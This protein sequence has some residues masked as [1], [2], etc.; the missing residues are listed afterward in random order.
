MDRASSWSWVTKSAVVP[1]SR[2]TLWTS[3]RT[4]GPQS[5]VERRERLVE[6]DDLGLDGQGPRQ[7]HPLLLSS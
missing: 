3:A 2:R 4:T 1:A 5:G 6:E 7:G